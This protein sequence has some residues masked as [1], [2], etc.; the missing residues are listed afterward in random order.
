MAVVGWVE[1][2]DISDFW[3]EAEDLTEAALTSYLLSAWEQCVAFLPPVDLVPYPN[4]IPERF[5]QAQIS[6][7]RARHRSYVTGS[8][9]QMGGEGLTVTVFPM[10]WEIKN[11]LRPSKVGRV[12]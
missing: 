3:P 7:A 6:Q 11:L 4:P 1:T 12:T 10:S 9:D 2:D 5:K 8:G